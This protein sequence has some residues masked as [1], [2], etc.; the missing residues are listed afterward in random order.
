M[1]NIDLPVI[2]MSSLLKFL[3]VSLGTWPA[4]ISM[5]TSCLTSIASVDKVARQLDSRAWTH[6]WCL[7]TL[8]TMG[9]IVALELGYSILPLRAIRRSVSHKRLVCKMIPWLVTQSLLYLYQK[10]KWTS[11]PWEV[12][13]RNLKVGINPCWVKSGTCTFRLEVCAPELG[14]SARLL[15]NFPDF[16]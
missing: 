5:D 15:S 2:E 16:K 11:C 6:F 13:Q 3:K 14:W 7:R 9:W 1:W 10:L 4:T 8:A 12:C